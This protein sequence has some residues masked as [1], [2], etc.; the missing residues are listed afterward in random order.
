VDLREINTAGRVQISSEA[1]D[2][3]DPI[4]VVRLSLP[5]QSTH[6][7][8]FHVHNVFCFKAKISLLL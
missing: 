6:A 8:V 1:E 2:L 5:N 7:T 3:E 4:P